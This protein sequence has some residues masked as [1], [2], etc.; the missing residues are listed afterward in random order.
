MPSLSDAYVRLKRADEHLQ[1]VY[2]LAEKICKAQAEA[3]KVHV[4]VG[5]IIGPGEM[6][7]VFF[8]ES[9]HTPIAERLAVLIGDS[10]NSLRSCLDYLVGELAELDSGSRKPR[11]QFPVEALPEAF[12][13][14][15]N[16]FLNGLNTAHIAN[17]ESLQPYN[18]IDWTAKL[19][20]MSNWDKHNKLVLVA[21]DY[22]VSVCQTRNG[23]DASGEAVIQLQFELQPSLCIQLEDGLQVLDSLQEIRRGVSSTLD[24]FS[25][26]FSGL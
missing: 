15:K 11:T 6:A 12:Q 23:P 7:E 10:V 8:V 22:L 19:A 1:G 21:H 5:Q 9:A 16:T 25:S 18:G 13:R 2:E 14:K 3:T 17:I 24:H 20:R 4:A 26:E